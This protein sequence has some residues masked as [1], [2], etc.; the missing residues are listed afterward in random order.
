MYAGIGFCS[1]G[2]SEEMA[3]NRKWADGCEMQISRMPLILNS[4]SA[5]VTPPA[6]IVV[7]VFIK[8]DCTILHFGANVLSVDTPV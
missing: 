7:L 4:D 6:S 2:E 8:L 1:S 3:Q 5:N